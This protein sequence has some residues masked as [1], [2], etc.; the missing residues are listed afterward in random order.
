[1]LNK[2]VK[3]LQKKIII[4][5]ELFSLLKEEKVLLSKRV[6]EEMH[7]MAGSIEIA[8]SRAVSVRELRSELMGD[9]SKS[10]GLVGSG[11]NASSKIKLS[12][13]IQMTEGSHKK[14]LKNL[15]SKLLLLVE[16]IDVLSKENRIVIDRG[17]NN[18]ESAYLFLRKI[19]TPTATYQSSGK[20]G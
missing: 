18:I 20:M 13:I 10:F 15:Q 5:E 11:K 19:A 17:I 1:M 12:S 9:L 6:T 2:L 4:Y 16:G 7:Q 3:T 8:M 14:L